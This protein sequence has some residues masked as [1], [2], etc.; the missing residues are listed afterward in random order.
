VNTPLQQDAFDVAIVGAGPAG[1]FAAIA[2]AGAGRR[3]VLLE[4]MPKPGLKLLAS[5][6]GK[7]N[8]TNL[9]ERADFQAAF[10]RQGRFMTPALDVMGPAALRKT[11][12]RLG[13]TTKVAD[14]LR[15]YPT[16][17]RA[18][19]VQ[20][21]LRRRADQLG[22]TLQVDRTVTGL[23]IRDGHL[24]GVQCSDGQRLPAARV[25]L[26]CGGQSYSKLGGTDLGYTLARQAGHA[27]APPLPALVPLVTQETW[28]HELAGVALGGVRI[29][30]ALPRQPKAGIVGDVML[31]HR[32]LSGPTILDMSAT[33]A[34]L[35]THHP[36]VPLRIELV[37]EMD[38]ARWSEQLDAWRGQ[39]PRRKVVN[40][41]RQHLPA[42]LCRL[43]CQQA[44]L[45]DET[46]PAQLTHASRNSLAAL[47]GGLELTVTDTEGFET[48]FVTKGGAKLKEVNPDTLESR[49]LPRLYF[50]GE[51]LDLDGPTGGFNL[52]WAFASGHLAGL[53]A[54][55]ADSPRD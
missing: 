2:A 51:L 44:G 3:T 52:Q 36:S 33:L 48:A 4:K 27:L 50:A 45:D 14:R 26:A 42:A 21:A 19:D 5:A 30:I 37:P 28:L 38:P 53:S 10:G 24:K 25:I 55:A 39:E 6:G 32:G 17:D 41:L 8:L 22:V 29:R 49:L 35:L 46:T 12:A 40:L 20:A 18:A 43:L 15:V 23:W 13:V 7:A 47:L 54:A 16:T 9:A 1:Q 31:T 11:L 34:E